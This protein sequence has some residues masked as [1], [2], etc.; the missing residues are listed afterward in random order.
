MLTKF[1]KIKDRNYFYTVLSKVTGCNPHSIQNNW[2]KL[3]FL[4]VPKPHLK[5]A[6][7]TIKTFVDYEKELQEVTEKLKIKYFGI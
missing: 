5:T 1:K 7:S 3:R 2:F 4:G 6:E